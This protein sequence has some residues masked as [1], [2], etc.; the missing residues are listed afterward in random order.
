MPEGEVYKEQLFN[1][2]QTEIETIKSELIRNRA[3]NSIQKLHPN[4]VPVPVTLIA[5]QLQ[6]TVFFELYAR[7]TNAAFSQTYLDTIMDEYLNYRKDERNQIINRS[8]LAIGEE[9]SALEDE[10]IAIEDKIL[11]AQQNHNI[12]ALVEAINMTSGFTVELKGQLTRLKLKQRLLKN[13]NVEHRVHVGDDL[14]NEELLDIKAM[15]ISESYMRCISDLAEVRAQQMEFAKYLKPKHPKMIRFEREIIRLTERRDIRKK[16]ALAEI[17][18]ELDAVNISVIQLEETLAEEE[19]VALEDNR[20]I[21]EYERLLSDR[22]RKKLLFE[23]MLD[24]GQA[25]KTTQALNQERM[26]IYQH[27]SKATPEPFDLYGG[28]IKSAIGGIL[29]G[30]L[31][32]FMLG[33]FERRILSTED[34]KNNFDEPVLGIVPKETAFDRTDL[35]TLHNLDKRHIFAEAF[36]TLRSSLLFMEEVTPR[37]NTY[38]ITSAVPEEGKSTIASNLSISLALA[39]SRTLLID[40]DLRRG[41]LNRIFGLSNKQGLSEVLQGRADPD[42][43][44]HETEI[45]NLYFL[46]RGETVN[47]SAELFLSANMD[48]LLQTVKHSYDFIIIDAAPIL[49]TDDTLSF[50]SKADA[51]LFIIRSNMI[52]LR[53]VRVSLDNLKMRGANISGFIM[54]FA[55][56]KGMDYYYYNKYQYYYR[57]YSTQEAS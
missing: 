44:I 43:C 10:L 52:R 49:A 5:L 54:N 41:H 27:A 30:M 28:I 36:R 26:T 42:D 47:N 16:Q 24:Q 29:S 2:F 32:I 6:E 50:S 39:S 38:I 51:V 17:K 18:K 40:A 15:D 12:K 53:Q 14:N 11:E 3:N 31:I 55:D 1:F 37:P 22:D 45:E 33:S 20:K 4:I 57:Y 25:F 35:T 56:T 23:K 7:S 8:G 13:L 21:A 46:P 48:E 9:S 19:H 34:I